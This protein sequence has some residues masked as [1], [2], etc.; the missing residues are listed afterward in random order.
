ML[1]LANR[2]ERVLLLELLPRSMLSLMYLQRSLVLSKCANY[3]HLE[4]GMSHVRLTPQR[5][6]IYQEL[7]GALDYEARIFMVFGRGVAYRVNITHFYS[8]RFNFEYSVKFSTIF[9]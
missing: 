4:E 2:C 7:P 9:G 6:V 8:N 3:T 1:D 5:V